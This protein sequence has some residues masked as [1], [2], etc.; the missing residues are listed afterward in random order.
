MI[1]KDIY[2]EECGSNCGLF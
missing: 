1:V 2:V